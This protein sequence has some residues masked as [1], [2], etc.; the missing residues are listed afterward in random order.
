MIVKISTEDIA[1]D[2]IEGR[3]VDQFRHCFR[4]YSEKKK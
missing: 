1:E 2:G 3:L 4:E